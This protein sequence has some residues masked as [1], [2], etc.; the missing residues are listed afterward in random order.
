MLDI[1]LDVHDPDAFFTLEDALSE[2][3]AL[4]AV[5]EPAEA[6]EEALGGN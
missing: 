4:A 2:A 3:D 5:A 1:K 6:L